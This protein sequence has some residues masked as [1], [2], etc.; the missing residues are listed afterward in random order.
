MDMGW[1]RVS[2]GHPGAGIQITDTGVVPVL[3]SC[4]FPEATPRQSEH[5]SLLRA[6][7]H[8]IGQNFAQ[9]GWDLS[10]EI[11]QTGSPCWHPKCTSPS[12]GRRTLERPVSGGSELQR[13]PPEPPRQSAGSGRSRSLRRRWPD[14]RGRLIRGTGGEP[15]VGSSRRRRTTR[16]NAWGISRTGRPQRRN[17]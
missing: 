17:L 15:A 5:A 8:S 1:R 13:L 6:P 11:R 7:P 2:P 12:V 9:V 3:F 16:S 14:I 10:R 4:F